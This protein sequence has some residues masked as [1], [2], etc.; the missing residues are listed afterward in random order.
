MRPEC[1]VGTLGGRRFASFPI[2]SGIKTTMT[3]RLSKF[4]RSFT[5]DGIWPDS[6][7]G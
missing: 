4:W 6:E 3:N 7:I 5:H 1:F 2:R